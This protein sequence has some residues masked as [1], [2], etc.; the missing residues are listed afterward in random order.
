[1]VQLFN[2]IMRKSAVRIAVVGTV[3][4]HHMAV[5]LPERPSLIAIIVVVYAYLPLVIFRVFVSLGTL[6]ATDSSFKTVQVE[7]K[8][9]SILCKSPVLFVLERT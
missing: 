7:P 4:T 5:A 8:K 2:S 9:L 6:L 1:M 3:S